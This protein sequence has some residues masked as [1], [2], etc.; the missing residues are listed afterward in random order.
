[1]AR[2][3]LLGIIDVSEENKI[4]KIKGGGRNNDEGNGKEKK[5]YFA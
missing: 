5:A 3:G 4:K 1:M 2:S